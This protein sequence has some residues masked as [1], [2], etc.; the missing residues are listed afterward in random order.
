MRELFTGRN[1]FYSVALEQLGES[2]DRLS[3]LGREELENRYNAFSDGDLD[4]LSKMLPSY[5]DNVRLATIDINDLATQY[6]LIL[7][8]VNTVEP[9]I[10]TKNTEDANNP[11]GKMNIE[12]T[13][14]G[15]YDNFVSFLNHLERSAR[16][17]DVQ[18]VSF[19]VNQYELKKTSVDRYDYKVII[20]TYWLRN[21]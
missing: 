5:V 3:G 14:T 20:S 7:K 12:F 9:E 15:S 17:I 21:E 4:I 19:D 8:D 11:I 6:G 18:S 13:L 10:V 1:G 2:L 16:I